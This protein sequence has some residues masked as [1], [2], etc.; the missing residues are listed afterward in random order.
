ML[1]DKLT[2][3]ALIPSNLQQIITKGYDDPVMFITELLGLPLHKGQVK[4]LR[5]ATKKINLLTPSN[6]W[7]KT[8]VTAPKHIWKNFYKHGVGRGNMKGWYGQKYRTANLSPQSA[9]VEACFTMVKQIMKGEYPIPQVDG[10]VRN[11]E[12]LIKYFYLEDKTQNTAPFRIFFANNSEIEFR[13]TG[14]DK[15]DSIQ[16]RPFGYISYDEGGRSDHLKTE[17]D[18]NIL[19]RLADWRG[20]LDIPS[21]PDQNS[22]SIIDHWEMHQKGLDPTN[23]HYYTQEGSLNENQFLSEE[24]RQEQYALYQGKAIAPQVLHGKFVFSGSMVFSAEEIINS[25]TEA[26]SIKE[27]VPYIDGHSYMFSIDTSIGSD[28]RVITVL[29][30]TFLNW[31]PWTKQWVGKI[32]QVAKRAAIGNSMSPQ[33]H[34]FELLDLYDKYKSPSGNNVKIALET[35]NGESARF[36]MDMPR[37]LQRITTCYGS[38]QPP[39]PSD[40]PKKKQSAARLVK[41]ADIIVALKKALSGRLLERPD[42]DEEGNKQLQIYKEDD[43]KIK[44]DHI[45]S[46]ALGVYFVTD[47][48][49]KNKAT[50]ETVT[51]EI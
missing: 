38:W 45:I 35:F 6:R 48:K 26:L 18:D 12:C 7:G 20:T 5:N 39:V 44:Q 43:A 46:L 40:A 49:P 15:G 31:D 29:D 33:M 21:T 42:D 16:G 11:N 50:G 1:Q 27:E 24:A 37:T 25:K 41:K 13:S 3:Q 4:W 36:Y 9:Q 30:D 17:I 23:P 34:Q 22:P 19:P 14:Q 2:A 8:T 10:S 47:G 32:T 51:V 28:E